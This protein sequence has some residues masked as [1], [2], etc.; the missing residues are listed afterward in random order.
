[1][2]T[3]TWTVSQLD[4]YPQYDNQTDVVFTVHWQLIGTDGTHTGSVYSTC[5]VTYKAD[6]PYT[7]YDQLTK[8]QVLGWIWANGVDKNS[9]EAAV[10]AQIDNQI[11]PPVISPQLPWTA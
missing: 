5:G 11:N 9:A 10:Q 8:N 7:P 4:C 3:F 1:M 6:T 2:T